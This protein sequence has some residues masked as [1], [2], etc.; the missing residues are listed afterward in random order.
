MKKSACFG[1]NQFPSGAEPWRGHR[2]AGTPRVGEPPRGRLQGHPDPGACRMGEPPP[3]QAAGLS[4]ACAGAPGPWLSHVVTRRA[5]Y[6]FRQRR[7]KGE[8][9]LCHTRQGPA[10]DDMA[11]TGRGGRSLGPA[12]SSGF[13]GALQLPRP[14]PELTVALL[15]T[16]PEGPVPAWGCPLLV[17]GLPLCRYEQAPEAGEGRGQTDGRDRSSPLCPLG[18]FSLSS[19]TGRG[20]RAQG[21]GVGQ[22]QA[23]ESPSPA[24]GARRGR[25]RGGRVPR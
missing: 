6:R 16:P 9:H 25:Q 12:W 18:C 13:L 19:C 5:A 24:W 22:C 11:S 3:G 17:C 10:S 4:P 14:C 8:C 23:P 7:G 1:K 21:G 2:P 15:R 20:L